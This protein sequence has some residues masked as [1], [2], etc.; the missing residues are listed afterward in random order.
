MAKRE[1]ELAESFLW[2]CPFCGQPYLTPELQPRC[3]V[4][5][6]EAFVSPSQTTSARSVECEEKTGITK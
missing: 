6:N 5:E 4:S 3:T 1:L 2:V